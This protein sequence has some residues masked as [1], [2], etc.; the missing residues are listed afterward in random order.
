MR[1]TILILAEANSS[2]IQDLTQAASDGVAWANTIGI[3][4]MAGAL[5]VSL[6]AYLFTKR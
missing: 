6:V 5:A 3:G 2:F 4:V 1:T